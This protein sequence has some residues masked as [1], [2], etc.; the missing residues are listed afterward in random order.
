ML[1]DKPVN[2]EEGDNKGNPPSRKASP[3]LRLNYHDLKRYT[4]IALNVL[5]ARFYLRK[6]NFLGKYIQLIGRPKIGAWGGEMYIHDKV[7]IDSSTAMVELVSNYGGRLEIGERT[8]INYGTSIAANAAVTIGKRCHIGTHCIIIDYDYH[9]IEERDN[10]PPPE[11]IT[12]GDN[13][14]LGARVIVLKGVT[15]GQDSVIAAG[16][17]VTKDIPPRSVAAGMPAKVIRTF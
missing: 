10:P 4:G 13:V 16:S 17:V 15:I 2:M 7:I 11:P 3:R 6:A 14:W 5:R 8:Y 12:I 9:G 1:T